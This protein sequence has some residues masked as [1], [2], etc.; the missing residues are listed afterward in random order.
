MVDMHSHILFGIDDG[1][2][3]LE[4]S[5]RMLDAAKST[6]VNKIIATPHAKSIHF[7]RQLVYE[8]FYELRQIAKKKGIT[9]KLGFEVHWNF[10][11]A[12][13]EFQYSDFCIENTRQMLLEFSLSA[14]E[15]PQNH[16][17]IIYQLQRNG[18]GIIIAHPERYRFVQKDY[19]IAERWIDLGCQ[20]QLDASCLLKIRDLRSMVLSRKLFISDMYQFVASD[21]HCAKDYED[22][23]KACAWIKK[24]TG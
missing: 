12:L 11:L 4:E 22:F 10:L 8:R 5:Q 19:S 15:L 13:K 24:Q 23:G 16:D 21:A 7:D 3:D 20:L 17:Q 18:I 6:Y 14:N 2:G 9:L 1:A